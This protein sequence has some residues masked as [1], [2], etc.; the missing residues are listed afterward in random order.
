[1]NETR[2]LKVGSGSKIAA[3]WGGVFG[4]DVFATFLL[5]DHIFVLLVLSI[6]FGSILTALLLAFSRDIVTRGID[7]GYEDIEWK[8]G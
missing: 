2:K 4:F 5:P 7:K 8:R 1:M 6:V 3:I